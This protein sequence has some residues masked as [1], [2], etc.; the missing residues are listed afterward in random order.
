MSDKGSLRHPESAASAV[1][2]TSARDRR[3][4]AAPVSEDTRLAVDIRG[5]VERGDLDQARGLFDQLVGMHQR[6]ALRIAYQYLRDAADAD[7]AV[8]DAFVKVLSKIES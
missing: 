7:E 1:P 4:P 2:R 8:Q 3:P 6:R 5:C